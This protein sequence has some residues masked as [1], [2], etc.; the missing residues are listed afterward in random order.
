MVVFKIH[1]GSERLFSSIILNGFYFH[2]DMIVLV[3][4]VVNKRHTTIKRK[5]NWPQK[6]DADKPMTQC[7]FFL[8]L[9]KQ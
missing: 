5:K 4:L 1:I 8:K 7:M 2:S 6:A 9:A 3:E